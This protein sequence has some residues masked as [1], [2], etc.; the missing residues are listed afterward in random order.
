MQ[1]GSARLFFG[2]PIPADVA[3]QVAVHFEAGS[4]HAAGLRL[5]P[6]ENWHIT[7]RFLGQ[8]TAE[9]QQAVE[10]EF[11]AGPLPPPFRIRL[12]RWGAFPR[13]NRAGVFWIGS[14]VLDGEF[15]RLNELAEQASIRAG[16]DPDPR[17]YSPHLTLARLR[18]P[19]D[20]RPLIG[21]LPAIDV[22][23][24]V[25]RCVLYRSESGKGGVRYVALR[26]WDL[27]T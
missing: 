25:D 15:A 9:R 27:G 21:N 17:P 6:R 1:E 20:L 2:V 12:D 7:V 3:E 22:L 24:P 19:A 5:T 4:E 11:S 16:F 13:P 14:T 8:T 26:Q 18:V 23:L 10:R